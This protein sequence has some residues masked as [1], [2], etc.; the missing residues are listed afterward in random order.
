MLCPCVACVTNWLLQ[1]ITK[2]ASCDKMQQCVDGSDE[3]RCHPVIIRERPPRI[4]PILVQFESTGDLTISSLQSDTGNVDMACPETHFWC[5]GKDLCLPVFVRCNSVYDCL[6]HEDEK[7]CDLY[8]CPGFYRCRASKIC[9]H[10][11]HVCDGWPLCPQLDDELLCGQACPLQCVCQGLAFFCN[12]VFAADEYPD[13]RYLDARGSGMNLDQLSDNHVLIHLSLANC[14]VKSVS[15]FTF[16]N[17]HSLDL[18]DNLLTE[19]SGHHFSHMPQLTVLFLAGNPLASVFTVPS[20]PSFQMQ[21]IRTLDLSRVKSPLVVPSLFLAFPKLHALNLSHCRLDL[22]QWDGSDLRVSLLQELDLRESV[23]T[24]FPGDVLSE[25]LHLQLLFTDNFKLCCPAVLPAGFDLNSCHTTPDVV[26]SCG[27]LLGSV[28]YR[29]TVAALATMSLFG[30][31]VSLTVRV[32]VRSTWRLSSGGVVLTHLSVADLGTGLY[33]ATLG[34]VDRLLTGHYVWQ[35]DTWRK[36]TVCHLAGVMALSCRHAATFFTTILSLDSCL[37]RLQ[38]QIPRLTPTKARAMCVMVWVFSFFLATVPLMSGW[39]VFG[40]QALC[41]PLAHIMKGSLESSYVYGVMM[42]LTSVMIAS[43]CVCHVVSGVLSKAKT[44]KV[45]N[46]KTCTND[47]QFV[48]LG[49]LAS[50]LLF[51]VA[52]LA[53]TDSHAHS[54]KAAHTALVYFGFLASCATNPYLHLY[55]VRVERS[56]RIKEER[57]LRI[58]KRARV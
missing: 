33:L 3:L 44:P 5:V 2:S 53:P 20:A 31:V 6:G 10:V 34:L 40:Q 41:V 24:K 23:I 7:D 36:G 21:N 37:A 9:V 16:R 47:I 57:L 15:K 28:M 13:L 14:T 45:I 4:P 25:F 54:Q 52:C 58:V 11:S 55:G 39:V 30:N 18:S 1:C 50:G 38:T 12:Q 32:C 49:S 56:K 19:V 27:S 29:A 46:T 43:C 17:L 42:L 26:S 35:D 51:T 48:Q 8:M 22:L